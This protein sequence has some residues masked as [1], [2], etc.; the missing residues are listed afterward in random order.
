MW[1]GY[2]LRRWTQVLAAVVRLLRLGFGTDLLRILQAAWLMLRALQ[3]WAPFPDDDPD[4]AQ[5][6][7][8]ELYAL[9]KLRFEL[10]TPSLSGRRRMS[11]HM[12]G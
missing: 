7:M 1:V 8:R 2:Y 12:R 11:S 4:G 6:C 9:V 5:T 3:L 10:L